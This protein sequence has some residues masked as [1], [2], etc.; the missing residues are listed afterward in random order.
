MATIYDV[1]KLAGVSPKTVSRAIN[2]DAPVGKKTKAAVDAAI[3]QLGY[4]PSNAARM[5]RSNK[6]GLI[7]LI[8]GAISQTNDTPEPTG[9]PDLFIV[10]GIQKVMAERG[11]TLM[12]AD[13]AGSADNIPHLLRTFQE[14][15]AEGILYVADYHKEIT[16]PHVVTDLTIVLANCFDAAGHPAILPDDRKGQYDLV[17][18]LIAAGH[19]RIANLRLPE[20]YIASHLRFAGY[21]AAM[22]DAGL[23]CDPALSHL[24]LPDDDPNQVVQIK[25]TLANVLNMD[26]PPT[27]ICCGNDKMALRVYGVLR[28]MGLRI[29]EDISVTGYDNYALIAE[30]LFPALT[31]VELP[32]ARMGVAAGTLLLDLIQSKTSAPSHPISVDGPVFWRSSVTDLF[33]SNAHLFQNHGRLPNE[34]L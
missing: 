9:L 8:T 5:M 25:S 3:T 16:L 7:G 20:N 26:A 33:K 27:V 10:Q 22:D 11:M 2:G 29:P 18:R 15:R 32:Y 4:V 14:H 28:S 21:Q 1:A 23:D 31:T 34:T 24:I 6:S 17:R 30:T 19:H 13:T 12:I